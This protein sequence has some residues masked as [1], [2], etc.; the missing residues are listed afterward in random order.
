VASGDDSTPPALLLLA[1]IDEAA[2]RPREALA[3]YD[4][5]LRDHP[6]H[7]PPAK[8]LLA[9]ARLLDEM[10]EK[11]R[12]REALVRV[13]RQGKGETAAEAAYRFA[14]T[15]SA[16][17]QH[18]TAAEWYMTAAYLAVGSKWSRLALLGAGQSL[19]A[20]GDTT[21]A[22]SVYRKLL[23]Q[24]A[25]PARDRD[26]GTSGEAAF[27]IAEILQGTGQYAGAVNLYLTSASL[28]KGSPAEGRALLGA[29]HSQVARGDRAAAQALYDRLRATNA[30]PEILASA[31]RALRASGAPPDRN[32]GESPRPRTKR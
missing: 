2:G 26:D 13:I 31:R 8:S 20:L 32:G 11:E 27:R 16:E 10:G 28:T 24:D 7:E 9:H 17:K 3:A 15:L 19:T 21:K 23:P 6:R 12:A 14:R 25:D 22:V 30:E 4:R 1:Q 18:A 5:V 29:L